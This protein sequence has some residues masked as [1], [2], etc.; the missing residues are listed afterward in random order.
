[1]TLEE[2]LEENIEM[3]KR[4]KAETPDKKQKMRDYKIS[5][6]A[7]RWWNFDEEPPAEYLEEVR[8]FYKQHWREFK[9]MGPQ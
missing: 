9:G 4:M 8:K 3:L 6:Y 1:M 2:L 7:H 5:I